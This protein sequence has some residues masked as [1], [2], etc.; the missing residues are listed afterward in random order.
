MKELKFSILGIKWHDKSINIATSKTEFFTTT[1]NNRK[2]FNAIANNS[3]ADVVPEAKQIKRDNSK[4]LKWQRIAIRIGY[5]INLNIKTKN[6][7]KNQEEFP[8]KPGK[9]V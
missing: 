6:S 3:I 1:S 2:P 8:F 5:N 7:S 4:V 9:N